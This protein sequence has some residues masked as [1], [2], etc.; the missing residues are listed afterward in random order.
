VQGPFFQKFEN[1]KKISFPP[2]R[3]IWHSLPQF[4]VIGSWPGTK[5]H[6]SFL[7]KQS[8]TNEYFKKFLITLV[9][10]SA[11]SSTFCHCK[12]AN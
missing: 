7:E 4:L 12:S 10:K 11:I 5:D 8:F 9:K 6:D 1:F 2:F 3:W